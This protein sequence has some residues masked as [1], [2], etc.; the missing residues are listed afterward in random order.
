MC[1]KRPR[2]ASPSALATTAPRHPRSPALVRVG[3]S[4]RSCS[5][6]L[7]A[8]RRRSVASRPVRSGERCSDR[9]AGS[10][11]AERSASVGA[12]ILPT[13]VCAWTM[14]CGME[15]SFWV[16]S[17]RI[18]ATAAGSQRSLTPSGCGSS[19]GEV[20]SSGARGPLLGQQ[21]ADRVRSSHRGGTLMF[22]LAPGRLVHADGATTGY[23]WLSERRSRSSLGW[24]SVGAR[25]SAGADDRASRPCLV[26]GEAGLAI[27]RVSRVGL[28]G[29][30]SRLR[31][32]SF[33][34]RSRLV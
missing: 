29:L 18:S 8:V 31:S 17:W 5:P 13:G 15:H 2:E 27:R 9:F 24:S 21:N 22:R 20:Q 33:W 16:D 25:S 1:G 7:R 4:A 28:P 32:R 11:G 34:L 3:P 14:M 19:A 10:V 23:L 6:A 30:R 26:A 12:P